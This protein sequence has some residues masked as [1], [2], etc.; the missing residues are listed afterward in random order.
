MESIIKSTKD[1]P[2]FWEFDSKS[3]IGLF[4]DTLVELCTKEMIWDKPYTS[5]PW[6]I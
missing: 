4:S 5:A 3:A 2:A 6:G 1:L